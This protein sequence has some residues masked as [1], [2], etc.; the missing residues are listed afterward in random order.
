M[1]Y[2]LSWFCGLPGQFL[3]WFHSVSAELTPKVVVTWR[4]SRAGRS[5]MASYTLDSWCW[6]LVVSLHSLTGSSNPGRPAFLPGGQHSQRVDV[7][8]RKP[9]KAQE[10]TQGQFCHMFLVRAN[11]MVSPDSKGWRNRLQPVGGRRG[12]GVCIVGWEGVVVI[13]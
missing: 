8:A 5:K 4:I 13:K 7:E 11:H 1:I 10:L 3:W 6:L 2:D 9:L 12:K